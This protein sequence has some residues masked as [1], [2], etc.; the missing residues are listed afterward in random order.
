[1]LARACGHHSLSDFTV[2]DLTS[3]RRE[4]ADLVGIS[5]AGVGGGLR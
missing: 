5:Y 3:W 1:V 4:V 2:T